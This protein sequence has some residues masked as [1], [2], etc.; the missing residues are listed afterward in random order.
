[1]SEEKQ[2]PPRLSTKVAKKRKRQAEAETETKTEKN[3]TTNPKPETTNDETNNKNNIENDSENTDTQSKRKQ[4]RKAK[5]KKAKQ[6]TTTSEE[7]EIKEQERKDGIDESIGKMDGTLLADYLAQRSRRLNK[8]LSAVE[9][10]D[11]YIPSSAFLDTTSFD[12][13][14]IMDKLPEFLKLFSPK[15]SQLS[16]SSEE[17]GS[18]HTIVVAPAAIRAADLVR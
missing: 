12:Q 2:Q 6:T 14:R 16:N 15:G 8:E 13:S 11:M 18:P 17:K 9:L 7:Q 3:T 1:M 5:N 4:K 10:E